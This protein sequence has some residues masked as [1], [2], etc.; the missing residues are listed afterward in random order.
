M[1]YEQ[2][3]WGHGFKLKIRLIS[4]YHENDP[5]HQSHLEDI[6]AARGSKDEGLGPTSGASLHE[7]PSPGKQSWQGLCLPFCNKEHGK[8]LTDRTK[9]GMVV[10]FTATPRW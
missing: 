8:R 7:D 2:Q 6:G 9:A 3:E 4:V 1:E 10:G 5:N